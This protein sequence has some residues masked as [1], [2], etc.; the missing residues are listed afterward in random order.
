LFSLYYYNCLQ[1]ILFHLRPKLFSHRSLKLKERFIAK[2]TSWKVFFSFYR[3]RKINL[4]LHLL[5]NKKNYN[6]YVFCTVKLL[7]SIGKIPVLLWKLR[8]LKNTVEDTKKLHSYIYLPEWKILLHFWN[9][10]LAN[11]F[12]EFK[13]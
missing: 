13:D 5:I 8:L 9:A 7:G 11:F 4:F 1:T 10:L 3:K 6:F 2:K 12:G